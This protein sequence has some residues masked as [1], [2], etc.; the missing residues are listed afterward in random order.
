MPPLI[1]SP[2]ALR[3]MDEE[4]L[5]RWQL[6][7]LASPTSG[8][9]GVGPVPQQTP[10][11]SGA[12]FAQLGD[13]LRAN[14][15]QGAAMANKILGTPAT[16]QNAGNG[17][18][19]I[20]LQAPSFRPPTGAQ[21]P[22]QASV[23]PVAPRPG[24]FLPPPQSPPQQRFSVPGNFAGQLQSISMARQQPA[25]QAG[26][27]GQVQQNQNTINSN[28][29]GVHSGDGLT[30]VRPPTTTMGAHVG[31]D[32]SQNLA[33]RNVANMQN[34]AAQSAADSLDETGKLAGS[35]EGQ[36]ELAKRQA[37]GSVSRGEN[38]LDASLMSAEAGGRFADASKKFKGISDL[39]R[40]QQSRNAE[41]SAAR[42]ADFAA[43][44]ASASESEKK[45]LE[46]EAR[47]KRE[48]EAKRY[49]DMAKKM[50]VSAKTG[51]VSGG[52]R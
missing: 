46:E 1:R 24:G 31:G 28:V 48:A 15:G 4:Q 37:I 36:Q 3:D 44:Q 42:S 25:P 13:Y 10:Q 18:L 51:N 21:I 52:R 38:L 6:G 45:R 47:K 8:A 33:V 12:R 40:G 16:K 27:I 32:A 41:A 17:A 7:A 5:K 19:D 39:V 43:K 49:S 35:F 23:N 29:P 50:T 11:P 26:T 22:T 2:F 9:P 30:L 20:S 34:Q 14:Q